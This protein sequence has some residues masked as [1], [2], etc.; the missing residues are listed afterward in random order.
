MA[1]ALV[2]CHA[3]E[4]FVYQGSLATQAS[5]VHMKERISGYKKEQIPLD[6]LVSKNHSPQAIIKFSQKGSLPHLGTPFPDVIQG[7]PE[8]LHSEL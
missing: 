7:E 3:L 2:I 4:L 6:L 1:I 8:E 5:T